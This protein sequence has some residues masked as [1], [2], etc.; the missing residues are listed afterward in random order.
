MNTLKRTLATSLVTGLV[1]L[2]SF[3]L[4]VQAT[5]SGIKAVSFVENVSP[6]VVDQKCRRRRG[7]N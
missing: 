1:L 3:A 6:D 5:E 7:C 4:Q 2:S